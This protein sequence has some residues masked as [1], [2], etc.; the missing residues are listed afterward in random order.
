[1]KFEL[2]DKVRLVNKDWPKRG[3]DERAKIGMRGI[4]VGYGSGKWEYTVYWLEEDYEGTPINIEPKKVFDSSGQL[5]GRVR[6]TEPFRL[7]T[8][9]VF[10]KNIEKGW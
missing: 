1:M 8:F 6:A 2:A 4:I 9:Y 7:Y 5:V 3:L 10:K